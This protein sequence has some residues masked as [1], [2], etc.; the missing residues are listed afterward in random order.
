MRECGKEHLGVCDTERRSRWSKPG[1]WVPEE[2]RKEYGVDDSYLRRELEHRV[3]EALG[4]ASV[5]WSEAPTGV[6]DSDRV[7]DICGEL[8]AVIEESF[9]Q[10]TEALSRSVSE[11]RERVQEL[12]VMLGQ[13]RGN[14]R[15][16]EDRLTTANSEISRLRSTWRAPEDDEP[17]NT[18]SI[19]AMTEFAASRGV[20]YPPGS[21]RIIVESKDGVSA[22]EGVFPPGEY[23]LTV[24]D[25]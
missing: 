18:M 12:T 14:A 2:Y 11:H 25:A 19:P 3:A 7:S 23:S 15:H 6:F 8:L 22:M 17:V 20:E 5:C 10:R 16:A 21:K 4:Q 9:G 24:R 1:A 13:L